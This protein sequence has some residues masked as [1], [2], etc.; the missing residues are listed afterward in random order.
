MSEPAF[1]TH[2]V[3]PASLAPAPAMASKAGSPEG[4]GLCPA[5]LTPPPPAQRKPN[6]TRIP[7]APYI[8]HHRA[9]TTTT[10]FHPCIIC[11]VS[12]AVITTM[13][14]KRESGASLA[15]TK[16]NPLLPPQR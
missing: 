1:S 3:E 5:G 4:T 16:T 12:G 2:R 7:K 15:N 9:Q 11:P 6:T 8:K 13:T 14:V 10:P